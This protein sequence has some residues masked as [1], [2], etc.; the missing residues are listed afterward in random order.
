MQYEFAGTKLTV[1]GTITGAWY[2]GGKL[3]PRE[4]AGIPKDRNLPGSGSLIIGEQGAMLLPHWSEPQLLPEEKFKNYPRPKLE[5]LDHYGQW[6]NACL[7]QGKTSAGFDYS[8][9]LAEVVLL[10]NVA[11]RVPGKK[12]LWD[13]ANMKITNVAEADQCLWRK[14]RAGW[15]VRG[16][17]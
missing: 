16:L 3:P 12:L 9:P 10:G 5:D 2:D 17:S 15:D 13:A 7:G 4:L 14:Y 1:G 6:V 11:V 8:G